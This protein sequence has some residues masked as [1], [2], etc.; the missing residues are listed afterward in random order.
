MPSKFSHEGPRP[1]RWKFLRKIQILK[2]VPDV[3]SSE[4]YVTIIYEG[5]VYNLFL[6]A[7]E[8]EDES[9][10]YY[11]SVQPIKHCCPIPKELM[12][13]NSDH[14]TFHSVTEDGKVTLIIAGDTITLD[15]AEE[16]A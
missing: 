9:A 12:R 10:L 5:H 16:K 1:K 14:Y 11:V 13:L 2:V 4:A 15:S 8:D 6:N 3:G 7:Y